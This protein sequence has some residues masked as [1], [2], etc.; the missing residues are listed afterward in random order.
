MKNRDSRIELLRIVSMFLIICGH[1]NY[2]AFGMP[3]GLSWIAFSR[4][5]FETL[6]IGSV[7]IFIVITGYYGTSFSFKR[8]LGLLF[9]CLFAVALSLIVVSKFYPDRSF[10]FQSLCYWFVASYIGLLIMTP[11]LNLA[12]QSMNKHLHLTFI[13]VAT[14]G[15]SVL[16]TFLPSLGVRHGYSTL[17]FCVVYLIGNYLHKYPVNISTRLIV[18]IVLSCTLLNGIICSI[19]PQLN[20]DSNLL[21]V[22]V[23]VAIFELFNRLPAF[24]NKHIN[25]ISSSTLMV[26][27]TNDSSMGQL[28]YLRTLH[29]IYHSTDSMPLFL[30]ESALWIVLWFAVA[31]VVGHICSF[32]WRHIYRWIRKPV[33]WLDNRFAMNTKALN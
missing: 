2:K 15:Y 18:V 21:I 22:V 17:W 20:T 31:I 9:Q 28:L 12:A 1:A 19:V 4:S 6:S 30:L 26:Y 25:M 27:L 33:E 8:I 24:E 7:M 5:A 13:L 10:S 16:D 32:C 11:V 29:K 14:V 23:A 3:H